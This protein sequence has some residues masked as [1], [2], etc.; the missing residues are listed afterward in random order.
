M[1]RLHSLLRAVAAA[2]V[3]FGA[4]ALPAQAEPIKNQYIVVLDSPQVGS[5]QSRLGLTE[6]VQ[7]LLTQV[8]GGQ[9]LVQYSQAL[10]GF[11][12]RM[13]PVQAEALARLPAVKLV[14][15]DQIVRINAT[16]SPA[17]WGLD[18]I[19][20]RNLP[21]NNTYNSPDQGGQGVHVYVLDTGLNAGHVEFTGRVG[22]GR[23]FASNGGGSLLCTLLGIGCP[24]PNPT[25]TADCNGHGT[26]V[27]GTAA[28]TT[29]GVAKRATIHAVRVLDCGGSGANSGVIAGVDWVAAN[30]QLPAVA[31]M[32]LGGGNSDALDVAVN[33]AIAQGVTFVVAAGNDNANACTGSPNRVPAAITVGSTTNTDARSSFSN[34]GTCLD[35]F[36]PGSNI[37]S[38]WFTNNTATS[39]ISGTSMA[40]PHVA[41][42]AAL[43][44]GANSGLTPDEVTDAVIGNA[45]LGTVTSPGAGS[46]NALLYTGN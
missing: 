7:G 28:G 19:D 4:V 31:N 1:S 39:T 44:L 12:A 3:V 42:A 20:Q 43:V 21:L 45:T 26:H 23:N 16:Q 46:P 6:L 14:E 27:S 29:Y 17:T 10:L 5:P 8:G 40:S 33:N 41:G 9:V 11:A 22:T 2:V 24:A 36:A 30:R 13:T 38:A 18:R 34:F 35:I 15:Q 32:S 37:T 25:N